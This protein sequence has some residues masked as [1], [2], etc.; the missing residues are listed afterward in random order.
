[1]LTYPH[2]KLALVV[3]GPNMW[4]CARGLNFDIDYKALRE[5]FIRKGP[6]IRAFYFTGMD[7]RDEFNPIKPLADW[8]D[9][10]GWRVVSKPLKEFTDHDG[11]KRFKGNMDMEIAVAM[12][13]LA[14]TVD[15]FVLFS[16]DGDFATLVDALQRRGRRVSVVSSIKTRPPV[17][18]D[19]LRR[20]ADCFVEMDEIKA[21]FTRAGKEA[22]SA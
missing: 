6:L 19:E 15:H 11:R 9:Y 12:L 16:G 10:N 2:E 20:Q 3:D 17:C 21:A 22:V 4:A 8:L 13:D 1:M 5:L 18:A 14:D 7:D